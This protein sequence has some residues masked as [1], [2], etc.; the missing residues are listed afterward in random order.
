MCDYIKTLK[1]LDNLEKELKRLDE[2][3]RKATELEKLLQMA[4]EAS[5]NGKDG[6][7]IPQDLAHLK[8]ELEEILQNGAK[9]IA[10]GDEIK[11][12]S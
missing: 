10:P 2:E 1:D 7:Y 4:L 5:K 12:L 3:I 11:L 6:F 8:T 9:V